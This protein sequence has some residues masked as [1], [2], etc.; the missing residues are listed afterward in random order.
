[1]RHIVRHDAMDMLRALHIADR[2]RAPASR[3]G[4]NGSHP[5]RVPRVLKT[6]DSRRN[7]PPDARHHA[8]APDERPAGPLSDAL[9]AHYC[10]S[11]TSIPLLPVT[12]AYPLALLYLRLCRL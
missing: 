6:G 2:H 7:N 9:L 5:E 4:N 8:H 12:S 10:D 1:M 3:K 11:Q